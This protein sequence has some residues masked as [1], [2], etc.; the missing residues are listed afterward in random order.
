M[1]VVVQMDL[2]KYF[3]FVLDYL[4]SVDGGLQFVSVN[5]E[6]VLLKY[7]VKYLIKEQ[8]L[9]ASQFL[10]MRVTELY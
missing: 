9:E 1:W 8:N 5:I 4:G 6:L 2:F 7:R 10:R 3:N